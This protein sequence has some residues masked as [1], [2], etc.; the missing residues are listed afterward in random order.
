MSPVHI[1]FGRAHS[2]RPKTRCVLLRPG[3]SVQLEALEEPLQGPVRRRPARR[4]L[5]DPP[6]LRRGPPR[7]LPL[8]R[9]RQ[10]QHLAAGPRRR[11]PRRRHERVEPAVPR[12]PAATG[13]ASPA[14]PGPAARPARRGHGRPAPWPAGP[15]PPGSCPASAAPAPASTGTG[16]SPGPAPASPSY[17]PRPQSSRSAPSLPRDLAGPPT[18]T[19]EPA[20]RGRGELALNPHTRA[21]PRR[22]TT[23]RPANETDGDRSDPNVTTADDSHARHREN[24]RPPAG[25]GRRRG[26]DGDHRVGSRAARRVQRHRVRR[27]DPGQPGEPSRTRTPTSGTGAAG[28]APC[29]R[30]TPDAAAIDRNPAP[31][32]ARASI[33][34]IT[35]VPSHRRDSS[36]AGQQDVRRRRTTSTA[37]AAAGTPPGSGPP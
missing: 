18:V 20:A 1:S 13:P 4:Q 33:S 35:A 7:L 27:K 21:E 12:R 17:P 24:P 31:R 6:D 37:T 5:Q 19:A 2:N 36:H 29:P 15:A 16:P 25:G 28:P 22:V 3:G 30:G 8:Q 9:L 11:L 23:D 26:G 32:A 34:P 10:R 14:T